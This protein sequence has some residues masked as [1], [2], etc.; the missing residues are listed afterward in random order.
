MD[1]I[2]VQIDRDQKKVKKIFSGPKIIF[3]LLGIILLAEIV[4][5]LKVLTFNTPSPAPV[6]S[7]AKNTAVLEKQTPGRV[8]LKA[9]RVNLA[10]GEVIPISVMV[11][12]GMYK[13]NGAD[14]IVRFDPKILEATSAS[15]VKGKIFDEYPLSSV[16]NKNGLIVVSGVSSLGNNFNGIGQFAI[17]NV[18]AKAAGRASLTVDY[19]GKGITTDSNLVEASTSKDILENVDN[20]ELIVQ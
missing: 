9:S 15:L 8:S 7:L 13:I 5:A 12:T 19:K 6:K 3:L 16:E 18:K 20:L 4:Y 2:S 10:P 1:D 17:I 11:D 14:L